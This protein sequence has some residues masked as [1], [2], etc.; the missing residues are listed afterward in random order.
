MKKIAVLCLLICFSVITGT[1]FAAPPPQAETGQVY[2]VQ[3]DDW[4]SKIADKYYGDTFAY[5]LIVEATNARATEDDSFAVIENPDLIEVGQKLWI[6]DTAS[7][8]SAAG[9][10]TGDALR[11]AT[12]Q[13]IY[14]EPVQL[15]DGKYEGKPFVEGGAARPTVTF[16]DFKAVG[17]LNGDGI[18]D[19]AV[20]LAENSGGSGVFTYL[21]AVVAQDG[22]AINVGTQLLGDRV[23]LKTVSIEDGKIVVNMITQGPDDPFCCPTLEVRQSYEVQAD[24]LVLTS[25]EEVGTL[26]PASLAGTTWALVS[27]GAYADPTP[28]LEGTEITALFSVEDGQVAGSAGCNNYFAGFQ[29]T[30][31]TLTI[32]PAGATMMACAEEVMNQES[33]YLAALETVSGFQFWNGRLM[34]MVDGGLLTFVAE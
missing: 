31:A 20:F 6:P 8:P 33:A 21:A 29:G 3:K 24:Q 27:H 14:E 12:Y 2:T 10:L 32:G 25:S 22:A 11:N 15:S 26:S 34:L 1:A 18:E 28:V 5:P 19:A 23:Q 16:V 4:L 9:G 17:D 13:G 7:A 30:D